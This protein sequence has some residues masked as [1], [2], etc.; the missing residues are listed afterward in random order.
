M[1]HVRRSVPARRRGSRGLGTIEVLV[2][3]VV[4]L[5]VLLAVMGFFDAQQKAFATMNAYSESQNVTRA[6][7][8]LLSR[9]IRMSSYDPAGTALT[10]SPGPTC[11]NVREGLV[12]ARPNSIRLRQD[13]N[14]DGVINATGEDVLYF[15][16]NN[17]LRRLDVPTS[18]V[19]VLASGV[20]TTGLQLHYFDGSVPPL[21]QVPS[22]SPPSL[23]QTQRACVQKIEVR[24]AA[25]IVPPVAGQDGLTSLVQSGVTIRNRAL[26]TF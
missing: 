2:G 5:I 12:T 15:I 7:V 10:L 22:G 16:S 25:Q 11:P 9:D 14:A 19:A 8:D 4:S 1:T 13:L 17:E 3:A 18:T 24:I 6:A 26:Q 20:A 21:E 23:T